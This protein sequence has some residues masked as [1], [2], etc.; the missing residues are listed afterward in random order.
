MIFSIS[1]HHFCVWWFRKWQFRLSS[2]ENMEEKD[3][4]IF[5]LFFQF[6]SDFLLSVNW[7]ISIVRGMS[8]KISHC[9]Y[10]CHSDFFQSTRNQG[11]KYVL[12]MSYRILRYLIHNTPYYRFDIDTYTRYLLIL[13][14]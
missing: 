7:K 1:M 13:L 4:C 12:H 3:E 11:F 5:S 8:A 10:L 9:Q 14:P 2:V 6:L